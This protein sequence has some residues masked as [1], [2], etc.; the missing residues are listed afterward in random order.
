MTSS[1][2]NIPPMPQPH[3]TVEVPDSGEDP[4]RQEGA[5]N[6]TRTG[7]H[8]F[9]W[10]WTSFMVLATSLP[11]FLNFA[12]TPAGH[13]YTWILP[14][15]PEDSL[16]YMAWSQQAAHGALLF[17]IKF[18]ALPQSAF[19]FHP[20]FLICGW[21]SGLLGCDIGIV[22]LAVKEVGVILFFVLFYKYVTYLRLNT[23]QSVVA[24]IL[25]GISSGLGGM[26]GFI[27]GSNA[28][29][30][31]SS[32]P[33]DLSMPEMST[34]WSLLWNPLF[35]YSLLL[36]LLAI[37]YLDRG[38]RDRRKADL[39]LGG[40]A[41]GVL[42][43]VH[44]YSQPLLLAFAVVI[45]LARRRANWLPYLLRYFMAVSPFLLY[46]VWVSEFQPIVLQHSAEGVM[47]SPNIVTYLLGFG[48]LLLMWIAG[49]TVGG[50]RWMKEY[51]QL[52][53]WFV[54]SL[55][56]AYL[57]FWFQRK[58]IFGAHIP[59]CILAAIS[60]D[61]ILAKCPRGRVR[62]LCL[63]AAVVVLL[64]LLASTPVYLLMNESKEVRD[65]SAG[66][67]YYISNDALNGFK[68][69][70]EQSKP[71]EVVFASLQT[72]RL[73]PAFSGNT[74][75]WGHWAMSVDFDQRREWYLDLFERYQDWNSD[76]RAS[77]FWGTGIE[78]VFVDDSPGQSIKEERWKWNAIL[79]D[80]D[81]VFRNGS[82]VIY[83][84]RAG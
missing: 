41:T 82:V 10:G 5:V 56:L 24:S 52:A 71:D 46:I 36:M 3:A 80:A 83:K 77:D 72:S 28:V 32:A 19:L 30:K 51:W 15:Y 7:L 26:A 22:H 48:F 58:L 21:I 47:S 13:H 31:L 45:V 55:A 44:P 34:Y 11:Y 4:T 20:F 81:E 29:N 17:K 68:F 62:K 70:K 9:R 6:I 33:A 37:F 74:V 12:F 76:K 8:A 14:P 53:I 39:W 16:S 38:T 67:V 18:T 54:M 42:A 1:Q 66:G 27:L 35:P 25:V 73:I 40:L 75:L 84:H 64:P 59:L 63:V 65:N 60:F 49:F 78:Y 69:L 23:F 79:K 2:E 50:G 57:P 43:L 61:L